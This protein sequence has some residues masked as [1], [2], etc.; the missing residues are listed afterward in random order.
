MKDKKSNFTVIF[1][2][3][4]GAG[5][6]TQVALLFHEMIKKGYK[7]KRIS[8]RANHTL[9]FMLKKM[10]IR[11]GYSRVT[12]NNR[13]SAWLA[14]DTFRSKSLNRLMEIVEFLSVLPLLI[15]KFEVPKSFGYYIVADRLVI[16][17]IVSI[18]YN[19]NRIQFMKGFLARF[20]LRLIPSDAKLVYLDSSYEEISKRRGKI[21][22]PIGF[23]S[24]QR[25][26][27]SCFATSRN[28]LIINTEGETIGT[29]RSRIRNYLF[30]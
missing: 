4:D 22:E 26:V 23:I 25:K 15:T 18:S 10:L 2:G 6:S 8:I 16:D 1:F 13:G 17:T 20:L 3:P 21:T 9:A 14:F 7:T 19:C 12:S 30:S 27:Y 5:K 11:L 28:A 24:L 29:T